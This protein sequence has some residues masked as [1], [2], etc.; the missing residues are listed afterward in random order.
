MINTQ[1]NAKRNFWVKVGRQ[2]DPN[3]A[4]ATSP[5]FSVHSA[6]PVD[7]AKRKKT[8]VYASTASSAIVANQSLSATGE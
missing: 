3:H 5:M 8:P 4:R 2:A 6:T 1:S 7:P